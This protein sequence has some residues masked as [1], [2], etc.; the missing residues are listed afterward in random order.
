[1]SNTNPKTMKNNIISSYADLEREEIRVKKRLR[2][3][4]EELRGRLKKLPEEL[5]IVGISRTIT[6]VM[7]GKML[8]TGGK[9]L[10]SVMSYFFDKEDTEKSEGDSG[11]GGIKK[12]LSSIIQGFIHKNDGKE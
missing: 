7:S 2:K 8:S 9:I 11:K 3:Q 12:I 5:I 10:R 4:E 1:M 6:T